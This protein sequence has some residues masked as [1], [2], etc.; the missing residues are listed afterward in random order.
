VPGANPLG[1]E[2]ADAAGEWWAQG[3]CVA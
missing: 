2:A 1:R 3:P